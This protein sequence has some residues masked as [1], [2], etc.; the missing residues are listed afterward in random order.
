MRGST[1]DGHGGGK[2]PQQVGCVT[3]REAK[4]WR[5]TAVEGAIET[6]AMAGYVCVEEK[7]R[8]PGDR[9]G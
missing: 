3:Y 5:L 2:F 1:T 7:K 9:I 8:L 4:G 6:L